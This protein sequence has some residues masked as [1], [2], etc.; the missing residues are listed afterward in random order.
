M[1]WIETSCGGRS[2]CKFYN[3]CGNTE[4]CKR[5]NSFE[6]ENIHGRKRKTRTN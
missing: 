6:K 3:A 4:N 2:A 5:C 1:I